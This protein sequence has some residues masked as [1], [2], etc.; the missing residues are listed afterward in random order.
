MLFNRPSGD[1]RGFVK[2]GILNSD[3][4][5][6]FIN[7]KVKSFADWKQSLKGEK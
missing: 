1:D 7:S 4:I 5:F 2:I 3:N 6:T